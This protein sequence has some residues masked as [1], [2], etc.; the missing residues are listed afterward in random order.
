MLWSRLFWLPDCA[1]KAPAVRRVQEFLGNSLTGVKSQVRIAVFAANDD[2]TVKQKKILKI[3]CKHCENGAT[4]QGFADRSGVR[5]QEEI[6]G[7][8]L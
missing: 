1:C 6:F 4:I 2:V 8:F 5:F 3:F 7:M